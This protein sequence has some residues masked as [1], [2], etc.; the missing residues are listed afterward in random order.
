[1]PLN[2][3]RYGIILEITVCNK[4]NGLSPNL[5]KIKNKIPKIINMSTIGMINFKR[6]FCLLDM[7]KLIKK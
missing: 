3:E 1:M 7:I 6:L 4:I 2:I 5:G